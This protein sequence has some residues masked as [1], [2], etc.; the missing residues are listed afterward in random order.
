VSTSTSTSATETV[1]VVS[2]STSTSTSSSES[3]KLPAQAKEI[4]AKFIDAEREK[5]Q[6]E[7]RKTEFM[8]QQDKFATVSDMFSDVPVE[9]PL[10]GMGG[11][12]LGGGEDAHLQDNWDDEE[13]YYCFRIGEVLQDRYRVFSSH[14]KGVFS[15]VLRAQDTLNDDKEVAIKVIRNNE[16]MY[17]A[18]V[19]ERDLLQLITGADPNN[20]RHCIRIEGSF[21][22]RNHL[23]LVLEPMHMDLREVIRKY[24]RDVGISMQAV[25]IYAKQLFVA[26]HHLK[27]LKIL[28]ADLK[29]DNIV[30]N[31]SKTVLKICDFGS[32]STIDEN[33]ITP[34]LVSR[35]YRAPEII[36]GLPYDYAIDMWSAGCCIYEM[37]TGKILFPGKSNNEM[38]WMI[39]ELKGMFS[40]KILRRSKFWMRHFNPD[41]FNFRLVATNEMTKQEYVR[42]VHITKPTRDLKAELVHISA[43][44]GEGAGGSGGSGS[45]SGSG[46]GIG[47]SGSGIGGSGSGNAAAIQ[48]AD[49]LHRCFDLN[50]LKRI[51]PEAALHHPFFRALYLLKKKQQKIKKKI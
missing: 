25:K 7:K 26:L 31:E 30:T 42:E 37:Y 15:T 39:M 34:Y 40:R 27:S 20:K 18:G 45:G 22:Y 1:P 13:G 28:H 9:L 4:S 48:L 33:S 51:T 21:T 11:A 32:A 36:L 2:T 49:L 8:Q 24:G 14:G 23:C 50:P 19:K 3:P 16:T 5:I 44:S 6:E 10:G 47:G 12:V 29:P 35:F 17:R 41:N 38:L 43:G 46:S